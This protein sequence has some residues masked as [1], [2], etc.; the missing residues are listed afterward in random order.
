MKVKITPISGTAQ[1]LEF[2]VTLPSGANASIAPVSTLTATQRWAAIATET[3]LAAG[4][5]RYTQITK[6]DLVHTIQY[7]DVK[8]NVR[9]ITNTASTVLTS[10]PST[11]STIVTINPVASKAVDIIIPSGVS[12]VN[13]QIM[14]ELPTSLPVKGYCAYSVFELQI[15]VTSTPSA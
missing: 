7:T 1:V 14:N 12:I 9:V 10:E 8:G 2:N 15:P 11:S 6:I 5:E 13:Q 3:D 4:G